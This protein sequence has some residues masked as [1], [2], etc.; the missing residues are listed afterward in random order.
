MS[1][2]KKESKPVT[3]EKYEAPVMEKVKVASSYRMAST[4]D[5]GPGSDAPNSPG[6]MG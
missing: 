1:E 5:F 4:A 6:Y 2:K 3:K